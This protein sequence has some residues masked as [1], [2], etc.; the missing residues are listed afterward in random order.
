MTNAAR[1]SI[2]VLIAVLGMVVVLWSTLTGPAPSGSTALG[3]DVRSGN[4]RD[5]GGLSTQPYRPADAAERSAAGLTPCPGPAADDS[6]AP[7][8]PGAPTPADSIA[9]QQVV[10]MFDGTSRTL[11]DIQQGRPML[12][13]LW[14]YWCE[15][16]RRELPVLQDAAARYN[17]TLTVALAHIDSQESKGLTMLSELGITDLPALQDPAEAL[18]GLV[19]APPVL[20]VTVLI[21]ADGTI[22]TVLPQIM[23]SAEVVDEAVTQNLD[24]AVPQ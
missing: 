11:G 16:C 19:Q 2:V 18:P 10:C 17:G 8:A 12:L 9:T 13:N 15:P 4:S 22:A 6:A 20:P 7:A 3:D 24:V 23:D 14:A 5:L 1:W 21:R